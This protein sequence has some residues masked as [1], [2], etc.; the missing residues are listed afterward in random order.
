MASVRCWSALACLRAAQ[1]PR[2]IAPS[3]RPGA[4]HLGREPHQA[5]APAHELEQASARTFPRPAAHPARSPPAPRLAYFTLAATDTNGYPK[6]RSKPS[7][8]QKLPLP[9]PV[10]DT[11]GQARV[12]AAEVGSIEPFDRACRHLGARAWAANDVGADHPTRNVETS[13]DAGR[14]ANP[15]PTPNPRNVE[16]R[17]D[18]S[19]TVAFPPKSDTG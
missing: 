9:S 10:T 3:S 4:P 5:H 17:N 18:A 6:S 8:D 11:T 13:S 19:T 2:A 7:R 15:A 1:D 16:R 12:P 14:T